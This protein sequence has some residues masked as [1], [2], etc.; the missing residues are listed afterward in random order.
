MKEGNISPEKTNLEFDR[1]C[2]EMQRELD[3]LRMQNE[4]VQD[5]IDTLKARRHIQEQD[6][7]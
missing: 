4:A 2:A 6:L 1:E 5:E 3:K 7:G